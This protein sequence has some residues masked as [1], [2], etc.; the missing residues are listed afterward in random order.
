[1]KHIIHPAVY[2]F[3]VAAVATSLLVIVHAI[4][5]E[6]IENQKRQTQEK[7]MRAVLP[8]ADTFTEISAQ[9]SGSIVTV[10]EATNRGE[11][12]GFVVSAAPVGYTGPIEMI[13]GIS[14]REGIVSGMRV[15]KHAETP[16]FG[17]A[18]TKAPFYS[19]FDNRP[20][21]PITV[22]KSGAGGNEIDSIAASTITTD[23]IVEGFNDAVEWYKG[24][25]F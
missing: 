16:G 14:S 20:L 25:G 17:D 3:V 4:T 1:M 13:V 11:R 24:G 18:A 19:K 21:N 23:A 6:P 22:V 12:E 10:Y 9:V 15:V 7:M 5:L 8:N 2:L